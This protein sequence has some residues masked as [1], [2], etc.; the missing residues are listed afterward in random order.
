MSE[1]NSKADLMDASSVSCS[2]YPTSPRINGG[3]TRLSSGGP[4]NT[5]NRHL[6]SSKIATLTDGTSR[7]L[8]T[9]EAA[10]ADDT[11]SIELQHLFYGNSSLL[12]NH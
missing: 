9:N 3:L 6:L 12:F 2:V 4:Y 7:N 10:T 8:Y 11:N 5:F 1:D